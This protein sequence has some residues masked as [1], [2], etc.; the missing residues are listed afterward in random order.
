MVLPSQLRKLEK[1]LIS[2]SKIL[3]LEDLI[4]S[5]GYNTFLTLLAS[6]QLSFPL[7]SC[8]KSTVSSIHASTQ[9]GGLHTTL[10]LMD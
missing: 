6:L 2:F 8:K 4:Y 3:V 1:Y 9:S 10:V 7:L 5:L